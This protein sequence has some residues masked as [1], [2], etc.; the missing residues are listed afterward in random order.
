MRQVRRF[1]YRA[2]SELLERVAAARRGA[3]HVGDE[4]H[5]PTQHARLR[6]TDFAPDDVDAVRDE[7]RSAGLWVTR[8]NTFKVLNVRRQPAAGASDARRLKPEAEEQR[9]ETLRQTE[10][11]DNL[12]IKF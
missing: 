10:A 12:R 4:W 7:L 6:T 1:A 8:C 3:P 9:R 11:S 5:A 2:R